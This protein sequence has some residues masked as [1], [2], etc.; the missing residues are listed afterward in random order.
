MNYTAVKK[1]L[2]TAGLLAVLLSVMPESDLLAARTVSGVVTSRENGAPLVG[3]TVQVRGSRIGT[4][5]DSRGAYTLTVPDDAGSLMVSYMGYATRYVAAGSG[6]AVNVSLSESMQSTGEIVVSSTRSYGKLK[7]IPRKIE[8]ITAKDIEALAPVNATELLKKTAGVDVK[9]YTGVLSGVSMRGFPPNFGSYTSAQYVTYLLDGRPLGTN[10][11]ASVNMNMIERVEVIKGPSSALY[12]SQGMGGTINFISKKS[13][14][15]IHGSVSLGY[16]SFDAFE[17]SGFV[18][19]SLDERFDF[20]LGFRY[21][22]QNEDYKVG[23]NTLISDPHPELLEQNIHTMENSTY[24]TNSGS[25]RLGYRLNDNFRVDLRGAFFSAPSVH[26]PG[27]IWGTNGRDVK[28]VYRKTADIA[29][30]GNIGVHNLRF[31]PYWSR[32]ESETKKQ[33]KTPK[34]V[35]KGTSEEYG[36]QL[37]DALGLGRH[38]LTVGVDYNTSTYKTTKRTI[39]SGTLLPSSSPDLEKENIGLFGE[40]SL[41]FFDERLIVNIGGR[42][43]RTAFRLQETSFFVVDTGEETENFFSPSLSMQYYII[44]D[45]LKIHSSVGRAF[46]SPTSTQKAG[47]FINTSGKL[48]RGNPDLKPESGIGWDAGITWSNEKKGYRVDVTYFD[49]S[50]DDFITKETRSDYVTYVNASKARI[51]G[52]ELEVSYDFGTLADY[53]Y[54]LRCFANYTHQFES[55]VRYNGVDE[56]MKYVRDGIGSFGIEYNDFRFL[57]ARLTARY[58]GWQY[59]DNWLKTN[60]VVR[61]TKKDDVLKYSPSMV[62][63]AMVGVSL[64]EQSTVTLTVK[65]LLDENYA[66]ADGYNMPGRS[67]GL[68]YSVNF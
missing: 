24:S 12:G 60:D 4:V 25:L 43:D 49:T 26:T 18:G 57:K 22:S 52:A 6:K 40:A 50:W 39:D 17:G 10:N 48:V 14:G 13:Q 42:Y 54:S 41:S 16:G 32:D 20:D 55:R 3:A 63:D 2:R 45:E 67:Y 23:R 47:E 62:F 66:E 29:F 58:M 33:S 31:I 56:D 64:T 61:P 68:R 5:T 21:Y 46:M 37:Q 51:R 7:N 8:V 65:N 1:M 19:G 30:T 15:P 34:Y 35:F 9:D 38:R 36:F 53:R 59:G 27:N 28:D 11:L 44:P